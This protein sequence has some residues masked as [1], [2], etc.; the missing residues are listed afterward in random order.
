M[1]NS[2]TYDHRLRKT[3]HPVRSAI[4]K[5]QIGRLVVG[6][7]TTSEYLLL[8]VF[9]WSILSF[10]GS[11][12]MYLPFE[13]LSFECW[14]VNWVVAHRLGLELEAIWK[15]KRLIITCVHIVSYAQIEDSNISLIFTVVLLH[16]KIYSLG[17]AALI[18][19]ILAKRA[20]P[21]R[22]ASPVLSPGNRTLVEKEKRAR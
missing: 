10:F 8:Y 22:T 1:I 17:N 6:W 11:S 2:A 20:W 19:F 4:H 5:P 16:L 18:V 15:W 13:V 9:F 14:E 21:Q 12:S 3:G 7:V